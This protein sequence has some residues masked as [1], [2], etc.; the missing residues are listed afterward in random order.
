MTKF[1]SGLLL[2]TISI[3]VFFIPSLKRKNETL[4]QE[5]ANIKDE[6]NLVKENAEINKKVATDDFTNLSSGLRSKRKTRK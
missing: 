4:E 6:L 1:L 2:A 5:S 3:I